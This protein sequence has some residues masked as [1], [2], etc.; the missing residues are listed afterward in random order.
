MSPA[1]RDQ[2]QPFARAELAAHR[3]V[4]DDTELVLLAQH[5]LAAGAAQEALE[6]CRLNARGAARGLLLCE[7]R[8]RFALG[9]RQAALLLIQQL[10]DQEPRDDLSRFYSAQF[11]AQHGQRDAAVQ[12]LAELIANSPDFPGAL[13]A[14]AQLSFPGPTY[15]DVLQLLHE[16]LRP[17]SYLEIGVESGASLQLARHSEVVLGID[18]VPRPN[19]QRL[20]AA[21]RLF[22]MTSDAFFAQHTRQELL[23][24]ERLELAFIDGMHWFEFVV[25]DFEN[26]E[27]WCGK[28]STIVLHDCL[29]VAGVAALRRR[30]TTFWVG[31]AW[32]A[33]K[34]LATQRP[35]LSISVIPCYPSGLVIIRNLDPKSTGNPAAL[36][37]F[38]HAH[39]EAPY[40]YAAGQWPHQYR[41]VPNSE[42]ELIRL[43]A[44]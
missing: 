19:S 22:H 16:R 5:Y 29:P 15:R 20:P 3:E 4:L 33:L 9:E 30:R 43:L 17:R 38:Q 21:T 10:L 32:K 1:A 34:Y 14:L 7:A 35:D 18:P 8:A 6:L 44:S 36:Q 23:G 24:G 31:D 41:V 12:A 39:L 13:P 40:P 25:R 11:L 42:L 27:R 2:L 37:S 26:V 28:S